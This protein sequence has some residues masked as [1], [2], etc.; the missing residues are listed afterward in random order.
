MKG[1]FGWL[2]QS[3]TAMSAHTFAASR[4]ALLLQF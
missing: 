1:L 3:F 4:A 2:W